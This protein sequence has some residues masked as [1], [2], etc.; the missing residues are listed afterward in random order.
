[1]P[2]NEPEGQIGALK[3]FFTWNRIVTLCSSGRWRV[4]GLL[5]PGRGDVGL[6]GRGAVGTWGC[7]DMGAAGLGE[8]LLPCR[9][10]CV[11]KEGLCGH[12]EPAGFMF[13]GTL[14][15][16]KIHLVRRSHPVER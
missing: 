15:G 2:E 12:A 10:E 14:F 7:G 3:P 5:E 11:F 16:L 9:G 6:W 4:L 1:M 13:T 8:L